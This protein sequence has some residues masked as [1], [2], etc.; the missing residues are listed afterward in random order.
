M[1]QLGTIDKVIYH[2]L[3]Q[4]VR[5]PEGVWGWLRKERNDLNSSG[6]RVTNRAIYNY[7]EYFSIAKSHKL[8]DVIR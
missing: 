3:E 1:G 6:R 8:A 4:G 5:N 2:E 7:F